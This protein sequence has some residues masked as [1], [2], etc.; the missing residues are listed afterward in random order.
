MSFTGPSHTCADTFDCRSWHAHRVRKINEPS[1]LFSAL[2][3]SPTQLN[4]V[5]RV[6]VTH[7]ESFFS[8]SLI[9]MTVGPKFGFASLKVLFSSR[10]SAV[11]LPQLVN[12]P[13]D[14]LAMDYD[15]ASWI[16]K[17]VVHPFSMLALSTRLFLTKIGYKI[18]IKR[19]DL[20]SNNEIQ[21]CELWRWWKVA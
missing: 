12:H 2:F 14:S 17:P 15:M 21:F 3:L 1:F 16:G 19:R 20:C 6:N 11:I 18:E 8:H 7:R 10:Y 13:N 5:C 4:F 9:G